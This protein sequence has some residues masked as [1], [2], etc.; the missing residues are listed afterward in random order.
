MVGSVLH[1]HGDWQQLQ[2]LYLGLLDHHD[3]RVRALAATCLGHVARVHR[4][5]D[6]C[7]VVAALRRHR[8][9]PQTGAAVS[10]ALED[11]KIF[12]HPGRTRWRNLMNRAVRP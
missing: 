10:N 4:Q 6:E 2:R 11:I 12:L 1:G 5:L 9:S 3:S 8:S 7:R